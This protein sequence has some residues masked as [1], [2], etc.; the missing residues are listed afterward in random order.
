VRRV[1]GT[2]GLVRLRIGVF[3]QCVFVGIQQVNLAAYLEGGPA[4]TSVGALTLRAGLAHVPIGPNS[5][6]I[7][8]S[9]HNI[10]Q[11]GGLRSTT[12]EEDIPSTAS[13]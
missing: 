2:S 8:H 5:T 1:W 13:S 3:L 6:Y 4:C 11:C 9:A 10:G 12:G 7:Q